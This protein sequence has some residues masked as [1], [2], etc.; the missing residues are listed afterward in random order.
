MRGAV[1]ITRYHT[2]TELFGGC[3]LDELAKQDQATL[4]VDSSF[5][6]LNVDKRSLI[7]IVSYGII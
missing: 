3:R 4:C 6:F 7:R 5:V 2:V 1:N